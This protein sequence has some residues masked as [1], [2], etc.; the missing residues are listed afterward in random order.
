MVELVATV[1]SVV[2]LLV[3]IHNILVIPRVLRNRRAWSIRFYDSVMPICFFLISIDFLVLLFQATADVDNLLDSPDN[4]KVF[5]D[6]TMIDLGI[7]YF[8]CVAL[9]LFYAITVVV[10]SY[11]VPF[12]RKSV[13]RLRR[14]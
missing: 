7:F 12:G 5:N 6:D 11:L 9:R 2:G 8:C 14:F 1:P 10:C 3:S 4:H 13:V